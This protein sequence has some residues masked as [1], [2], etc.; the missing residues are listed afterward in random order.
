MNEE[1]VNSLV[2]SIDACPQVLPNGLISFGPKSYSWWPDL[3]DADQNQQ[4]LIA[5]FWGYTDYQKGEV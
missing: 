5:A 2:N 3:T 4:S 1:E